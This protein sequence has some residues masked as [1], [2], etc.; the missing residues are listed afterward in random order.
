MLS[1]DN[2]TCNG[3]SIIKVNEFNTFFQIQQTS[4]SACPTTVEIVLRS[5]KTPME[6]TFAHV[7]LAIC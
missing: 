3:W 4:M 2:T 7:R 1:V 6:A 5:V